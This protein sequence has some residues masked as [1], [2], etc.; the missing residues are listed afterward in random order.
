MVCRWY[1]GKYILM[2][3]YVDYQHEYERVGSNFACSCLCR[4]LAFVGFQIGACA[5]R[6]RNRTLIGQDCLLSL[7]DPR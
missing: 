2:H 6:R 4:L 1:R 3:V 7:P 5:G